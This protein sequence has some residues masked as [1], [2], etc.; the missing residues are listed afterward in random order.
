MDWWTSRGL[1]RVVAALPKE[2]DSVLIPLPAPRVP[3]R[4]DLVLVDH[5]PAAGGEPLLGAKEGRLLL[6][7]RQHPQRVRNDSDQGGVVRNIPV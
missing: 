5:E 6:G 4:V 2:A 7:V 1:G 3:G